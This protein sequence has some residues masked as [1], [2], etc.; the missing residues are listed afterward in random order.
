MF[1]AEG[2]AI[3]VKKFFT[4][5]DWHRFVVF[6]LGKLYNAVHSQLYST[7]LYNTPHRRILQHNAL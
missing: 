5:G 2:I 6:R 3:L 1:Y 4:V 7:P